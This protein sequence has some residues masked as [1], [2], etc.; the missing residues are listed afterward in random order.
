MTTTQAPTDPK[1]EAIKAC[2]YGLRGPIIVVDGAYVSESDRSYALG[3]IAA[4]VDILT[5]LIPDLS[6][7]K[8]LEQVRRRIKY[9]D[10]RAKE[11][12]NK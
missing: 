8:V 4:Y 3:K 11:D 10:R 9:D 7:E 6:R 5:I 1:V 2:Y 12:A